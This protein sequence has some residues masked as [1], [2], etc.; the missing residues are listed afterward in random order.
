MDLRITTQNAQIGIETTQGRFDIRQNQWPMRL[1]TEQPMLHLQSED[2]VL[3]IDQR[4]CFSEAGLKSN[5]ELSQKYASK[6]RQAALQATFQAAR[7]G[8]EL[9]RISVKGSAIVRQAK[10]K[11]ASLGKKQFNFDMI[12]KSRPDI[13]VVPG[14]LRGDLEW[15]S[16]DIQL[17]N[18]KPD[19]NYIKGDVEIY[20]KQKNYISFE[21]VGE[22]IDVLGG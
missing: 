2:A 8:R 18:P 7:D 10:R 19:I 20:L 17:Q 16:I 15:A 5:M 13:A 1:R 3:Y 21:Y 6:G 22:G 14:K 12:P 11:S 9:A 4:R